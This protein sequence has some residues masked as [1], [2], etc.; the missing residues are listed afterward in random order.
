MLSI[1]LFRAS[2]IQ[3]NVSGYLFFCVALGRFL[4]VTR[5]RRHVLRRRISDS[6][7]IFSSKWVTHNEMHPFFDDRDWFHDSVWQS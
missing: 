4:A 7:H 2:V 5:K 1:G 6:I 3:Q